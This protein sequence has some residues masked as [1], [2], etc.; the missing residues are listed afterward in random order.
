[1]PEQIIS[2]SGTQYGLV[3]NSDGSIN[4]NT[5]AA[6]VTIGSVQT[7]NPIGIGSVRIAAQGLDLSIIGSVAITSPISVTAGS[8]Q[9]IKGGSIQ[10]YSPVGIGSI[11]FGGGIGSVTITNVPVPISGI[12]NQ[13][14]NPWIVLGS[15]AVTSPITVSVGSETYIKGGS[16]QTYDP[17][18]VGSVTGVITIRAGSIQTY[19]PLGVGSITGQITI[20]AGSIQTYS[21]VGIGSIWFGGGIGSVTITNIVPISGTITIDN[22]VAGSIVNMPIVGVSGTLFAISGIVNQGNPNVPWI[23][24]PPINTGFS[25]ASIIASGTTSLFISPGAGSKIQLKAFSISAVTASTARV[26]FNGGRLIGTW[27]IPNSGTVAM[28]LY[29]CEP[30]GATNEGIGLGLIADG[31]VYASFI[32]RDIL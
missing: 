26:L 23:V 31:S 4:A 7:Y 30:S 10:T 20:G 21:P 3:V 25:G 22:R 2:A 12:V 13:G 9:Y 29:G 15:V 5:T 17:V 28:N 19:S 16:V 11:W 27:S 18:G 24:S 32:T 1:M 14:T 6:Q 8:E